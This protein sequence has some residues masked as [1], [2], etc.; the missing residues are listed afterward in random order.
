MCS[1]MMDQIK[2]NNCSPTLKNKKSHLKQY[3]SVRSS[4]SWSNQS[5]S[6]SLT[7]AKKD[8][9]SEIE[10]SSPKRSFR[11]YASVVSA[12]EYNFHSMH[13]SQKYFSSNYN[14]KIKP[15]TIT[16]TRQPFSTHFKF[17]SVGNI[18]A[19]LTAEMLLSQ[20]LTH[21]SQFEEHI[22]ASLH[23]SVWSDPD[24]LLVIGHHLLTMIIFIIFFNALCGFCFIACWSS[25]FVWGYFLNANWQLNKLAI[26]RFNLHPYFL[27]NIHA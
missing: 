26:C 24:P 11:H 27:A 10:T 16:E 19:K 14:T 4:N 22:L 18:S 17:K 5:N 9:Y 12:H 23:K 8:N 13:V 21:L 2:K 6:S 25:F 15:H 7:V 3:L 20:M 1:S